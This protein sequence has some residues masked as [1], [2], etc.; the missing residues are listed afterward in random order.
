L[1]SGGSQTE[2][3]EFADTLSQSTHK[4]SKTAL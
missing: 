1:P 4:K 3:R 2:A